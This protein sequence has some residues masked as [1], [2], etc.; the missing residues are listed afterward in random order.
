VQVQ[1][2]FPLYHP[3]VVDLEIRTQ[4]PTYDDPLEGCG[5][6]DSLRKSRFPF[7]MPS[8]TAE[9]AIKLYLGVLG[10][11]IAIPKGN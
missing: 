5:L 7:F 6:L 11:V 9:S 4:V 1:R 3:V 8:P 10:A 2:I